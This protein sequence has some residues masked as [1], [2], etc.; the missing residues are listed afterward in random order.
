MGEDQQELFLFIE[1]DSICCKF[2]PLQGLGMVN[3]KACGVQ[4][5]KPGG[6]SS[7][8]QNPALHCLRLVLH[9]QEKQ[10]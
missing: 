3:F 9:L 2:N 1:V 6:R 10:A 4:I 5:K 8:L 7:Y